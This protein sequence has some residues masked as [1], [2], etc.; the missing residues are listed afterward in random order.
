MEFANVTMLDN[1]NACFFSLPTFLSVDVS[2][3]EKKG[4]IPK[5]GD[6]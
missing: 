6:I 3:F 4:E 2:R 1:S 5:V